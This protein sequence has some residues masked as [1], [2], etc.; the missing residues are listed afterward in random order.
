MHA[1]TTAWFQSKDNGIYTINYALRKHSELAEDFVSCVYN[2]TGGGEQMNWVYVNTLQ[3]FYPDTV[4]YFNSLSNVFPFLALKCSEEIISG[5]LLTLLIE[6]CVRFTDIDPSNTS[7]VR[8]A[9]LSLL[10]EIWMTFST[11]ID[12]N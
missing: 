1:L 9:A 10:S 6:K 11:F 3:G 5:N 12:Q 8:I 4:E 7:E 2:F